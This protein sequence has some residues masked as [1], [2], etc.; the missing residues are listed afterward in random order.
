[1][2]EDMEIHQVRQTQL[3]KQRR[4][5]QSQKVRNMMLQMRELTYV[6]KFQCY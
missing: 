5:K 6:Y 3:R 4:L 2:D 1:M